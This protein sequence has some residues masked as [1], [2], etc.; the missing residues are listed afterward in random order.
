MNPPSKC[1]YFS[2]VQCDLERLPTQEQSSGLPRLPLVLCLP[3]PSYSAGL[4]SASCSAFYSFTLGGRLFFSSLQMLFLPQAI[5]KPLSR[6][7]RRHTVRRKASLPIRVSGKTSPLKNTDNKG[8][9][10][11]VIATNEIEHIQSEA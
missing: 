2:A 8:I 4:K 9:N 6:P 5:V 1:P 10:L 3:H 7:M 11:T